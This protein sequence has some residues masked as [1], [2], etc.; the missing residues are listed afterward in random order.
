MSSQGE[1]NSTQNIMELQ[2]VF[3]VEQ[4]WLYSS[5]GLAETSHLYINYERDKS[6]T[7]PAPVK[8]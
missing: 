1:K 3:F 8:R 5:D 7:P 4:T 2:N 6:A